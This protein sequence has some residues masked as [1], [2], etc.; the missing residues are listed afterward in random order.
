I[1]NAIDAL[2][3]VTVDAS[4]NIPADLLAVE[5][6]DAAFHLASIS[7]RDVI[8]AMHQEIFSRFCIGK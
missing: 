2:K 4:S 1:T 6:N 3:R 8:E 7:G 5:L